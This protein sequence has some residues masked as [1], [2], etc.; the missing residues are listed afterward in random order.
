MSEVVDVK[1]KTIPGITRAFGKTDSSSAQI[2]ARVSKPYE[3]IFDDIVGMLKPPFHYFWES[4]K[5]IDTGREP[6]KQ[7]P[8][9][10]PATPPPRTD[11]G[12][13]TSV[14]AGV[15]PIRVL[16]NWLLRHRKK[17][18]PSTLT[19]RKITPFPTYLCTQKPAQEF[20]E[21]AFVQN[22]SQLST[23]VFS[24][25]YRNSAHRER[26]PHQQSRGPG[27]VPGRA[28]APAPGSNRFPDGNVARS[29]RCEVL[30]D[31]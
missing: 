8:R 30:A 31:T 9:T 10:P 27:P 22:N 28:P 11:A 18:R 15:A 14:P 12:A 19:H 23:F 13:S 2:N 6:R 17:S 29:A 26:S 24:G 25:M 21:R 4:E 20:P 3:A 7:E 5:K 1:F 16:R